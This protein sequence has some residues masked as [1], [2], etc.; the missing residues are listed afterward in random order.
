MKVKH[1]E[2]FK[3]YKL[4]ILFNDNKVKI[5]DIEPIINESKKMFLPLKNI[6]YF[7]EVS[8]DDPEYPISICWPNGAD[9]CPDVLYE[10]GE[11]I[12]IQKNPVKRG[13]GIVRIKKINIKQLAR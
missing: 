13:E 9:I 6:D 12:M 2:Y 10:I 11:E 7:K 8:L 1:V 4:K 5:V 3:D